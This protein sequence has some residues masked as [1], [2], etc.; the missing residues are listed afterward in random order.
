M[1]ISGNVNSTTFAPVERVHL[2][3]D[4]RVLPGQL[5]ADDTT[6]PKGLIVVREDADH[7][8][9]PLGESQPG[10]DLF[11]IG[12]LDEE[13]DTAASAVGLV[14]RQGAVKKDL[15]RRG[16]TTPDAPDS[17][18]LFFLERRGIYAL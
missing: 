2:E 16:V 4:C 5:A 12:V 15:L 11:L 8:W 13:V 7:D 10:N 6:W 1:T 9:T 18:I 14:V 3:T 17:A